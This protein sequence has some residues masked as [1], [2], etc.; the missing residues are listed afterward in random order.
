[1]YYVIY[2]AMYSSRQNFQQRIVQSNK[3]TKLRKYIDR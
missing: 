2:F 3:L 1:M